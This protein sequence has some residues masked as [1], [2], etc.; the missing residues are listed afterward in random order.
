MP[1]G[2]EATEGPRN[3]PRPVLHNPGRPTAIEDRMT[4]PATDLAHAIAGAYNA[5]DLQRGIALAA[6]TGN[7]GEEGIQLLLGLAQQATGRYGQAT[8]TFRQLAQ[9]RQDASAYWNNLGVA[10][11]LSGE[12]GAAVYALSRAMSHAPAA[13]DVLINLGLLYTQQ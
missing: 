13:A 7:D 1:Q 9:R 8:A 4:H 3:T 2:V 6:E 12:L 5:G 10:C 11:R